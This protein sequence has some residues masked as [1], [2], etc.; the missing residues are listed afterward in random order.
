MHFADLETLE[1]AEARELFH[2]WQTHKKE[3]GDLF[4]RQW[5]D[6]ALKVTA[7]RYRTD[8]RVRGYMRQMNAGELE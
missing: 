3:R 1:M 5:I 6:K 8:E 2:T 7:K 4:A